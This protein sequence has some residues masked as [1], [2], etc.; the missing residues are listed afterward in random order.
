MSDQFN[1]FCR[2]LNATSIRPVCRIVQATSIRPFCKI[3]AVHAIDSGF[4]NVK[5]TAG[6]LKRKAVEQERPTKRRKIDIRDDHFQNRCQCSD[7]GQ[8]REIAIKLNKEILR[9]LP[10]FKIKINGQKVSNPYWRFNTRLPDYRATIKQFEKQFAF[11]Y[12]DIAYFMDPITLVDFIDDVESDKPSTFKCFAFKYFRIRTEDGLH[13]YANKI[14]GSGVRRPWESKY[15]Y[16]KRVHTICEH[17][18]SC[19]CNADPECNKISTVPDPDILDPQ[20]EYQNILD[21]HIAEFANHHPAIAYC[22]DKITLVNVCKD[23]DN[24]KPQTFRGFLIKFQSQHD[25]VDMVEYADHVYGYRIRRPWQS[26]FSFCHQ[27]DL[28]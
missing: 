24:A 1:P 2:I 9:G 28:I 10:P 22:M 20:E 16:D 19:T 5:I 18:N 13:A 14:Y 27:A 17:L 7:K 6:S 15:N 4:R 26:D 8:C 12:P 11:L 25:F 23:I 3:V 21:R